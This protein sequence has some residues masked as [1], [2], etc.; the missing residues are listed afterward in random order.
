MEEHGHIAG[1]TTESSNRESGWTEP[2]WNQ[3][4]SAE[5]HRVREDGNTLGGVA[6]LISSCCQD[7]NLCSSCLPLL[8]AIASAWLR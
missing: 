1:S 2:S 7:L 8:P 6:L 3:H 4:V 5:Q